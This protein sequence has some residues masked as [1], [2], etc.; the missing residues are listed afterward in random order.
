MKNLP[1]YVITCFHKSD[2]EDAF[3]V[4]FME[5]N[6]SEEQATAR[7]RELSKSFFYVYLSNVNR[8]FEDGTQRA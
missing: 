7:C 3:Y 8:Y 1:A 6:A 4:E 2:T 5:H